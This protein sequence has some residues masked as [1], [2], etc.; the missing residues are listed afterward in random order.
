MSQDS[1]DRV[2]L[3]AA[4]GDDD[5]DDVTEGIRGNNLIRGTW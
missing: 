2:N 1:L 5:D 4:S 3:S